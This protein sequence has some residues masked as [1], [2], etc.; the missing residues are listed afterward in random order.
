[1]SGKVKRWKR[2]HDGSLKE[3]EHPNPILDTHTYEVEFPVRQV[4]EYSVNVIS[5]NMYT[6]CD[7]EGNQYLILTKSLIG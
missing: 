4:A 1:M 5:E 6:Q 7:A 2:E 3:T